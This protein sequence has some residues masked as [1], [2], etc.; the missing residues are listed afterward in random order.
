MG[1]NIVMTMTLTHCFQ[2]PRSSLAAVAW[3]LRGYAEQYSEWVSRP[4]RHL[5]SGLP[6]LKEMTVW[7][8]GYPAYGREIRVATCV[9]P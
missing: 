8:P 9:C 3:V 4:T 7:K 2:C 5:L 1:S 6:I